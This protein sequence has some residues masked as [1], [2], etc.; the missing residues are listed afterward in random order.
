ML[1]INDF[2]HS[3]VS[4]G[5]CLL[6]QIVD[7]NVLKRILCED[8]NRYINKMCS[9]YT[10]I[11]Y[12]YLSLATLVGTTSFIIFLLKSIFNLSS[13]LPYRFYYSYYYAFIIYLL[14]F[15]PSHRHLFNKSSNFWR[16]LHIMKLV[17]MK[18]SPASFYF[19]SRGPN[20]FLGTLFSVLIS[21]FFLI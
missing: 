11:H 13:R 20:I 12:L 18:V 17:F 14:S 21:A 8:A 9:K 7:N 2:C 10:S 5:C 1:T 16:V 19:L 4:I 6:S 15:C 3:C